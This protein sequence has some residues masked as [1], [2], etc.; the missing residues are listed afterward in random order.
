VSGTTRIGRSLQCA[1]AGLG[2]LLACAATP[3]PSV[4]VATPPS[5][6]W[7]SASDEAV[8]RR[9]SLD[10]IG[11]I[12]TRTEARD[13]LSGEDS[14]DEWIAALLASDAWSEYWADVHLDWWLPRDAQRLGAFREEP[15]AWLRETLAREGAYVDLVAEVVMAKGHVPVRGSAGV[16]AAHLARGGVAEFTG[17]VGERLL[18]L[19]GLRCAQCH[20]HPFVPERTKAEFESLAA[21]FSRTAVRAEGMALEVLEWPPRTSEVASIETPLGAVELRAGESLREAFARAPAVRRAFAAVIVARVWRKLVGRELAAAPV[22]IREPLLRAFVDTDFDLRTL[23]AAVAA[24][25]AYQAAL[26]SGPAWAYAAQPLDG[27]QV[28]ASVSIATSLDPAQ[29]PGVAQARIDEY[30]KGHLAQLIRVFN[31]ADGDPAEPSV[32]QS[33]VLLNSELVQIG[34][35]ARTGSVIH[36]ILAR[37]EDP[38]ERIDELF[39]ASLTR[40]PTRSEAE[41][42]RLEFRV[43]AEPAA[44][45][46]LFFALLNSVEFR[47]KT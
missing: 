25:P 39:W 41:A 38:R 35:V 30:R 28:F 42:L 20:D 22:E 2:G 16:P 40:L 6:S 4:H 9:M 1:L 19:E 34:T 46:D 11:R 13:F 44:Y 21:I 29:P 36:E 12:P 15:R 26:G 37:H 23:I 8:L 10:L 43:G 14:R 45:E 24:T 17:F 27:R 5:F 31:T 33:L 47:V 3:V 32:Q 18:G 7:V